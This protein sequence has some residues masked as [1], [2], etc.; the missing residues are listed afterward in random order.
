[1]VS[2]ADSRSVAANT[3]VGTE[4]APR[5]ARAHGSCRVVG[6]L[7]GCRLVVSIADSRSVVANTVV[8]TEG[9]GWASLLW[10]RWVVCGVLVLL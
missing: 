10:L 6:H 3:V 8:R 1:M 5:V 9:T 7:G 2:I 4:G